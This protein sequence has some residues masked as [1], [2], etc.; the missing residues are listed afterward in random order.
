MKQ[1]LNTKS[2]PKLKILVVVIIGLAVI[3]AFYPALR[4]EEQA[5]PQRTVWD[6]VYTEEQAR[7]GET[8][9]NQECAICHFAE[10]IGG[11]VAT[12][13]TGPAFLANW[14][15][16][17]VGDLSERIRVSM[18]P[19]KPGQLSRR[20]IADILGHMLKANGFPAGKNELTR[21][22]EVLKQIRIDANKPKDEE[23]HE[24]NEK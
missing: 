8:L 16:L 3:G 12:A 11:E 13:L 22:T 23:K 4:A 15:G 9:Y 14:D 2:N 17:T 18:P 7:R 24:T 6:G 21:D 19:A 5:S 20:Q 1:K 10:G